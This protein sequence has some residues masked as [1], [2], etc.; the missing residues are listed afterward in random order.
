MFGIYFKL[1]IRWVD[2]FTQHLEYHS[3]V[4]SMAAIL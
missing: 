2:G 4:D 1:S 3:R